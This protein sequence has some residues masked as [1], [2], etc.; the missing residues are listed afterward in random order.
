M[1]LVLCIHRILMLAQDLSKTLN[2][3]YCE[4]SSLFI[5]FS[6]RMWRLRTLSRRSSSAWISASSYKWFKAHKNTNAQKALQSIGYKESGS[7]KPTSTQ[8]TSLPLNI[9]ARLGAEFVRA[10]CDAYSEK[11]WIYPS[12][13]ATKV[14]LRKHFIITL[15][16]IKK[17]V[18]QPT[19]TSKMKWSFA[20]QV[21]YFTDLFE[22]PESQ[23]EDLFLFVVLCQSQPSKE[24]AV[25]N[26]S[27]TSCFCIYFI[28]CDVWLD[29]QLR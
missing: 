6:S 5:L 10:A 14:A 16:D 4:L 22:M 26:I 23:F 11:Q 17:A 12:W 29:L 2:Q 1:R 28:S 13:P 8:L 19:A 3:T 20:L 21:Q 25:K 7:S 24:N 27:C 9:N 18:K 15:V